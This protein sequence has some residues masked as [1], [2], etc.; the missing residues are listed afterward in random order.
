MSLQRPAK[1]HADFEESPL[2]MHEEV[3]RFAREHH[4]F[5]R[6]IDPL[7][8]ERDGGLAQPRDKEFDVDS[9]LLLRFSL[10]MSE[11]KRIVFSCQ[12][13]AEQYMLDAID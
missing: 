6:R 4:R 12:P 11:I 3:A 2:R 10:D 9:D 13:S 1:K 5:V 7:I 8:P